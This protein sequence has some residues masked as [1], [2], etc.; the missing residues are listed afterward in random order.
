MFPPQHSPLLLISQSPSL[1]TSNLPP[2]ASAPLPRAPHLSRLSTNTCP[3]LPLAPGRLP[4]CSLPITSSPLGS[5]PPVKPGPPRCPPVWS[6]WPGPAP[7]LSTSLLSP[8][9]PP[10]LFLGRPVPRWFLPCRPF[11]AQRAPHPLWTG[12]ASSPWGVG[13]GPPFR[14]SLT[15]LPDAPP[16]RPIPS[17]Q[18]P[19]LPPPSIHPSS[20]PVP[21]PQGVSD[22]QP[23]KPFS[24]LAVTQPALSARQRPR[25]P[26]RPSCLPRP[27]NRC[28]PP[29]GSRPPPSV[30]AAAPPRTWFWGRQE[31]EGGDQNPRAA[32]SPAGGRTRA[33][34][35]CRLAPL[36]LPAASPP[37]CRSARPA[38]VPLGEGCSARQGGCSRRRIP[39]TPTDGSI[40]TSFRPPDASIG[41]RCANGRAAQPM[42]RRRSRQSRC[43]TGPRPARNPGV[44]A[45]RP[46]SSSPLLEVLN[47]GAWAPNQADPQPNP[48]DFSGNPGALASRPGIPHPPARGPRW[49]R[50]G[51]G[52]A[53]GEAVGPDLGARRSRSCAGARAAAPSAGNALERARAARSLGTRAAGGPFQPLPG[54]R[55]PLPKGPLTAPRT[56]EGSFLGKGQRRGGG[57]KGRDGGGVDL[58]AWGFPTLP[59]GNPRV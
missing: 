2:Q 43:S 27:S 46:P 5:H 42:R 24:R 49:Q 56:E 40:S 34:G 15:S 16:S 51:L 12:T 22:P 55:L 10:L 3:S 48:S 1:I 21:L 38:A 52:R 39:A 47:P 11:R 9:Q 6:P 14:A 32:P 36:S 20:V 58:G 7:C 23:P 54:F 13:W 19:A 18:R 37:A 53:E 44:P 8:L 26:I 30:S 35:V 29:I 4:L 17:P 25:P 57:G 59:H 31:Q 33:S 45:S 41:S 28:P 50:P